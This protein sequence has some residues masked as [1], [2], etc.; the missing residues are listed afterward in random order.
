MARH[1]IQYFVEALLE[2]MSLLGKGFTIFAA[3][4]EWFIPFFLVDQL[5]LCQMRW[6]ASVNIF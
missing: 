2:A 1:F 6:G 4:F 3:G 5:K